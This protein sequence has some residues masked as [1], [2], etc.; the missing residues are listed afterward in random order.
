MKRQFNAISV[1][2]DGDDRIHSQAASWWFDRSMGTN[3]ATNYVKYLKEDLKRFNIIS[4]KLNHF[5]RMY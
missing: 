5:N 4:A 1:K 3:T 2:L